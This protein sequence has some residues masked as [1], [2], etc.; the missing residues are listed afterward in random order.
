MDTPMLPRR[1][2]LEA[3]R[4]PGHHRH[5]HLLAPGQ[6]TK[7]PLSFLSVRCRQGDTHWDV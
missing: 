2:L 5:H 6:Y 4:D 7:G 1:L 3:T